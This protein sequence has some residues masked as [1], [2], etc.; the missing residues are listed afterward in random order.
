M[1]KRGQFGTFLVSVAVSGLLLA[2]TLWRYDR[3]NRVRTAKIANDIFYF[4]P[5]FTKRTHDDQ[6]ARSGHRGSNG[7]GWGH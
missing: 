5:S 3:Y 1:A 4:A 2:I 6:T 7:S